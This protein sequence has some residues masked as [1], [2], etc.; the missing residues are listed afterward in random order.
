MASLDKVTIRNRDPNGNPA[1][2][3]VLDADGRMIRHLHQVEL[4]ATADTL[5]VQLTVATE[6]EYEGAAGVTRVRLLPSGDVE[7][8]PSRE[9]ASYREWEALRDEYLRDL[10]TLLFNEIR[11]RMTRAAAGKRPDPDT[12]EADPIDMTN[13]LTINL[14]T[15]I[16]DN[17][18]LGLLTRI[19][20]EYPAWA[21]FV[22]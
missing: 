21:D 2:T 18:R 4:V 3:E 13:V 5:S 1:F 14:A 10:E 17:V 12:M 9:P 16:E 15:A 8:L 7:P 6:W 20:K 11:R 19:T 22:K